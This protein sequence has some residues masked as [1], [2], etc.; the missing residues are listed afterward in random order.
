[1]RTVGLSLLALLSTP[2]AAEV[3]VLSDATMQTTACAYGRGSVAISSARALAAV[4]L[5]AFIK[6]NNS[7]A[8]TDS[9]QTIETSLDQKNVSLYEQQRSY[10][11]EGL[12]MEAI[13]LSTSSPTLS[14]NDT[15]VTVSLSL[16]DLAEPTSQG[17]EEDTQNISV[18]VSGEG[19]PKNGRS[20]R[21]Y[22]EI[23]ALQRAVSQVVGVWLTQQHSQ[24]SQLN[25]Q[26][27]NDNETT[28]MQELIGQ[29]LSSHSE[30][31]VTEWQTLDSQPMDNNGL[32]VTVHA[33][34]E[35]APLVQQASQLLSVIGS[36]RVKV[37]APEPLKTEL[38]LWLGEQGVEV[39]NTASLV[40][41]ADADLANTE[42]TSRLHLNVNVQDLSGNV[43][44][45][46][47]N[48]PAL[49][50]LPQGQRVE[51]DLMSVHLAH[52]Q[53]AK[54]LK[55]ALQKAFTQVVARGGLV[56]QIW[57]PQSKIK[58]PEKLQALLSTLGGVSDVSIETKDNNI[59]ASLRFKGATGEL[60]D[61]VNQALT[62][63]GSGLSAISIENDFTLRYR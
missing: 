43:Y 38:T 16:Q 18:T 15:C 60:A 45:S 19:W 55:Q 50:A 4:E 28:Q 26:V 30:G 57:L 1:M 32:Q 14:G 44:G 21:H 58:Q 47:K 17:W 6:G 13:P 35:K 29:Q 33:V 52:E 54:D 7:L 10:L 25:L 31:L 37:I 23:D 41:L 5:A 24:S 9:Q 59:V 8:I 51:Q 53:Q 39:A 63:R 2:L 61:A 12:S 20:A 62:T 22:A 48:N 3:K 42:K 40:V 27:L 49:L 46:W 11:L 34:V 56:R 36:P